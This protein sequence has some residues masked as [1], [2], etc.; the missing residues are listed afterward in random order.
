M[1]VVFFFFFFFLSFSFQVWF[2]CFGY[3]DCWVNLFAF[4]M[5]V[6][7]LKNRALLVNEA[8]TRRGY[9]GRNPQRSC[10]LLLTKST[11]H[12]EEMKKR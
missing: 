11:V 9:G 4:A 5:I 6:F 8:W 10:P 2:W 12:Q 7:G 3:N 1:Y